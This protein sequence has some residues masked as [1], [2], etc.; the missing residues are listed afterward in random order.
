MDEVRIGGGEKPLYPELSAVFPWVYAKAGIKPGPLSALGKPKMPSVRKDSFKVTG[1]DP[2]NVPYM[3]AAIHQMM[4]KQGMGITASNTR[5]AVELTGTA[6]GAAKDPRVPAG[7]PGGGTFGTGNNSSSGGPR[8]TTQ[9]GKPTAHQQ[10]MAHLA[11]QQGSAGKKAALLKAAAGY[12]AQ[13]DALIAKRDAMRK[14]LASAS[15]KVSKGQAGSKTSGQ[16]GST[17]KSS[18]PA[19][20]S[21][22][23]SGTAAAPKAAGKKTAAAAGKASS[24][25]LKS[26]IAALNVQIVALQ[27]KYRQ[28]M[29]QAK[30]A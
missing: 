23:A 28:A 9:G 13:A 18:A 7:Q 17:T 3:K 2:G 6:A 5:S 29:A 19:A 20:K 21:T 30:T 12:R 10:H 27:N 22:A 16:S 26:Q 14:A 11:H 4:Q 24:A 1:L 8:T 25:Q 15:G